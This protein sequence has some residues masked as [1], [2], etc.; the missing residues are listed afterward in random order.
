[1]DIGSASIGP[2][3]PRPKPQFSGACNNATSAHF[4][5]VVVVVAFRVCR[6]SA[7]GWRA[8]YMLSIMT[9]CDA[10]IS[11]SAPRH[12]HADEQRR[13]AAATPANDGER[14]RTTIKPGR[15]PIHKFRINPFIVRAH[16][17][18]TP[19]TQRGR[20]FVF[21]G[22]RATIAPLV[23]TRC[24]ARACVRACVCLLCWCI[25]T[26]RSVVGGTCRPMRIHLSAATRALR[27]VHMP[28]VFFFVLSSLLYMC[29]ER[30]R[31]VSVRA[32]V[33]LGVCVCLCVYVG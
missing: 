26:V 25:E 33:I 5:V 11:G 6:A 24:A 3:P 14:R 22:N 31:R 32:C 19:F 20:G 29:V 18:P 17:W 12:G 23:P 10:A 16:A 30:A 28:G 9:G 2:K 1:M 21:R 8:L 15:V 4:V 7:A 27:A 13:A